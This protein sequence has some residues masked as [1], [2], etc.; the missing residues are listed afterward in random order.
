MKT[1]LLYIQANTALLLRG[2]FQYVKYKKH[3]YGN[4]LTLDVIK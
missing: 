1:F 4:S 3:K 2:H